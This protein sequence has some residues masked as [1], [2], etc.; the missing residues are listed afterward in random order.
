VIA[1]DTSFLI[2]ALGSGGRMREELRRAFADG[3]RIVLPTLVL[4]EWLRGPRTAEE[5]DAQGAL[6]PANEAIPFGPDEAGISAELYRAVRRPKGRE[7]DFAIAAC[8][9]SWNAALWTLNPKDF[10][11]LPGLRLR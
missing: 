1:L 7:V 5:I 2:E 4:Y 9:L 11:D 10:S 8:A 6:F 3:Q